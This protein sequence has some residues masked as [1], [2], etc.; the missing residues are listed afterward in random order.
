MGKTHSISKHTR[1]GE[2]AAWLSVGWLQ[3][4][5]WMQPQQEQTLLLLLFFLLWAASGG[6]T[7]RQTQAH[8][9]RQ[10]EINV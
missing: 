3:V 6:D 2:A 7:G 9:W 10:R 4:E 1:W 5:G 8:L